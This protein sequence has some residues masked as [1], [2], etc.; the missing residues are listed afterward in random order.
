L[1]QV[2]NTSTLYGLKQH[3]LPYLS[4]TPIEKTIKLK[5][6]AVISKVKCCQ[7]IAEGVKEWLA[8]TKKRDNGSICAFLQDLCELV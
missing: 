6:K 7:F 3:F 2:A 1:L 4:E 8:F 5:K